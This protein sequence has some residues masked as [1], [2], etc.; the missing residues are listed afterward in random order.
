[1]EEHKP[2]DIL[3]AYEHLAEVTGRM[4]A[5]A[6]QEDW[7]GVIALEAEC[8]R[9][10]ARLVALDSA[11]VGDSGYERRKSELICKLLDDD[12]QIRER[13]SGQLSRIWKMIY[14]RGT[15]DRLNSAYGSGGDSGGFSQQ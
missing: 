10:Y 6:V 7:D 15:I 12:A 5:A 14:G 8:A 4:R 11:A 2:A 13:I 9:V 3:Q 1:M